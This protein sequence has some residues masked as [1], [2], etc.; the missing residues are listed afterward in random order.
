M[1]RRQ[2]HLRYRRG[3]WLLIPLLTIGRASPAW[4]TPGSGGS[5]A[6]P[7]ARSGA[8]TAEAEHEAGQRL[9]EAQVLALE[10][11]WEQAR[12]VFVQAYAVHPTSVV[13]WDLAVA[14]TKSDHPLDAAQHFHQYRKHPNA[15]PAKLAR[16]KDFLQRVYAKIGRIEVDA[17]PSTTLLI[18]G[19]RVDWNADQP[20]VIAPGDH[21]IVLTYGDQQHEKT[22]QLAP[23][24]VVPLVFR[25]APP[26]EPVIA[27][28]EPTAST[29][30]R[31]M[32]IEA[33]T[34]VNRGSSSA[35]TPRTVVLI[36]GGSLAVASAVVGSIFALKGWSSST[37]ANNKARALGPASCTVSTIDCAEL[38]KANDDAHSAHRMAGISFITAGV[39]GAATLGTLIFWRS[40]RSN[41]VAFGANPTAV[42]MTGSF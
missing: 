18:D 42:W 22:V 34:G 9:S 7:S 32:D 27:K 25:P 5:D 23:G 6:I 2:N 19:T 28:S 33:D 37:D 36:T 10:G 41:S 35:I 15:E 20:N 40:P 17:P 12:L 13:L 39:F 30:S 16:L 26:R 3:G 11:K 4:A 1:K 8:T 31:R 29:P 24:A 21:T 38:A 14:E